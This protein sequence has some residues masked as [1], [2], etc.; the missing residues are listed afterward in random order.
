MHG[1]IRECAQREGKKIV[2]SSGAVNPTHWRKDEEFARQMIAGA[3]PV[4]IKLVTRF[5]LTSE[6]DRG[7]FGHQDSKITKDHVEKNMVGMT[8]QQVYTQ[9]TAR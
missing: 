9:W 2:C 3:N 6:L 8:V 7:V 4:C 1:V 5:P